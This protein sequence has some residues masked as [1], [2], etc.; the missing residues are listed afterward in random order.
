MQRQFIHLGSFR[1]ITRNRVKFLLTALRRKELR[2]SFFAYLAGDPRHSLYA[3][4][5]LLYIQLAQDTAA[6]SASST[7]AGRIANI[8]RIW[9][10]YFR[11]V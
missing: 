6:V 7:I 3:E 4:A 8:E 2:P 10:D 1:N 11:N 9:K 5:G